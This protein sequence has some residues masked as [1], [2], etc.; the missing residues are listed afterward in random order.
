MSLGQLRLSASSGFKNSQKFSFSHS[1]RF[2]K[3]ED[4]TFSPGPA[5]VTSGVLPPEKYKYSRTPPC[6]FDLLHTSEPRVPNKKPVPAPGEYKVEKALA[7]G[8]VAQPVF[9]LG[10]L[11][12]D[13]KQVESPGPGGTGVVPGPADLRPGFKATLLG[14]PHDTSSKRASPGPGEYNTLKDGRGVGSGIKSSFKGPCGKP[15]LLAVPG[16]GAYDTAY[17]TL[18]GH[19]TVKTS[20]KYSLGGLP[21]HPGKL[22]RAKSAPSFSPAA[23]C[24]T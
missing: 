3:N 7:L 9:S 12:P 10:G 8:E 16:P 2:R 18:R 6:K 20:P 24:F 21:Q 1:E 15:R 22:S 14:R 11:F 23:T 13:P 19:C 17:S 4:A 5:S